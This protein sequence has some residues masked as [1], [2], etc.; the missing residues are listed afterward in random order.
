MM[1]NLNDNLPMTQLDM[2]I[3]HQLFL[4]LNISVILAMLS[5]RRAEVKGDGV[6]QRVVVQFW[7]ITVISGH[8]LWICVCL[9]K[10]AFFK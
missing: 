6:R 3:I 10:W 8:F 7:P 5:S 9:L 2:P 1:I 4:G